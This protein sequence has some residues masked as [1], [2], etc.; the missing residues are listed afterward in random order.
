MIEE[1]VTSIVEAEETAKSRV[2]TAEE[3]AS[4]TVIDA[5]KLAETNL[6]KASEENKAYQLE[7]ISKAEAVANDKAKQALTEANAQT[8]VEMAKYQANVEKA[9]SAILEKVL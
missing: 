2:A 6:K 8:D 4:Q 9:V 1:V 3:Q 7:Q 5:E